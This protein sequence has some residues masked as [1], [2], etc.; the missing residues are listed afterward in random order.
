MNVKLVF[1]EVLL[2]GSV[3]FLGPFFF[4][5]VYRRSYS[6]AVFFL[7]IY[8]Q[9]IFPLCLRTLP[10]FLKFIFPTLWSFKFFF[11]LFLQMPSKPYVLPLPPVVPL[12]YY[13]PGSFP[14]NFPHGPPFFPVFPQFHCCLAVFMRLASRG[15][16]FPSCP[17]PEKAAHTP[18]TFSFVFFF[19]PRTTIPPSNWVTFFPDFRPLSSHRLGGI[20]WMPFSFFRKTLGFPPPLS[21][22]P[23]LRVGICGEMDQFPNSMTR[24]P[25]KFFVFRL[26][27]F[28]LF[29]DLS[30]L[31]GHFFEDL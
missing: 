9:G 29:L 28:L 8:I 25:Y 26:A 13:T 3:S 2:C 5:L 31:E 12:E 7:P 14:T 15:L 1:S 23:P 27:C 30:L 21:L 16:E 10:F 19:E 20:C 22:H 17:A 4:R 24:G 6:F 11:A 18:P